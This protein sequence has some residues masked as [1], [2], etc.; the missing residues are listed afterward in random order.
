[1]VTGLLL[2]AHDNGGISV[3]GV[4]LVVGFILGVLIYILGVWAARETAQPM[5]R[6]AGAVVGVIV[7]LVLGFDVW[8]S[9]S[10]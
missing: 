7:F 8:G 3:S 2:A 6:V 9:I 10:D 5:L 1:M 4:G